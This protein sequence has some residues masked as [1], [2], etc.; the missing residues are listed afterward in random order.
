MKTS[1]AIH[2]ALIVFMLAI[3]AGCAEKPS[4]EAVPDDDGTVEMSMRVGS[5]VSRAGDDMPDAEKIHTL[6]AVIFDGDG[7]VEY[8]GLLYD[9][10][11]VSE[12]AYKTF[13]VKENDHKTIY[14]LA[15]CE[16]LPG[17]DQENPEGL[18]ERIV[19]YDA[20]TLGLLQTA[21]SLPMTSSY[22]FSV[23]NENFDCGTLYVACAAVKFTFTFINEMQ[24]D[25]ILG[26]SGIT[27]RSV[28]S[29]SW[30]YPHNVGSNWISGLL[31]KE[32][33]TVYDIPKSAVHEPFEAD[34]SRVTAAPGEE[35]SVGP[36]YITE[37]KNIVESARNEQSYTLGLKIGSGDAGDDLIRDFEI[38]DGSNGLNSLFRS[39]HVDLK[40]R[41]KSLQDIDIQEGIYG[42]INPWE[43]LEEENGTIRPVE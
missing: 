15:N 7:Q 20:V 5:A 8:N 30:L 37:S 27:I 19:D 11:G 14:L 23:R 2:A 24:G 40:I 41:V 9:G 42:I 13:K 25:Q 39:T 22:S 17:L 18:M 12:V 4:D 32:V 6:R 16:D 33:I 31:D 43:E 3:S 29:T 36:F 26:V 1:E 10:D 34:M 35:L 28:A 21:E 38:G